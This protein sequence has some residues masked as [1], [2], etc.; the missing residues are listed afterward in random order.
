MKKA[1][2]QL[3]IAVF[4]AGFTAILGKLIG[5]NESLLVWYR[6][7]L[8]V[9]ALAI[10]L[11]Y[12]GQLKKI[13]RKE[14]L[15]IFGVGGI[16]AFHWLTFYGSVKYANVSVAVVCL[17][18][19]G[20][21]TAFLEPL[22]FNKKIKLVEV[23]L[24]ILAIAGIYIIFDFHPQYKVGIVFG[25]L[26]A[27]GSSLFPIFNKRL[28]VRYSPLVLTFYELS[29]G[30]LVLTLVVPL[31]LYYFPATY[32]LPT[33]LDGWWLLVLA[34]LCTVVC[35]DLQLNALKKISPF[36]SNLAYNLEPVYGIIFAFAIFQE[37]KSLNPQFYG[38]LVLII[39]AVALQTFR[40]TRLKPLPVLHI[41]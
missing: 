13:P 20:F 30:I 1:L 39:L 37:N 32:Y 3:H 14:M 6:L 21:F 11:Y 22:I 23:L 8:T 35:F 27:L 9:I 4:L 28:I 2:I 31:Y 24:G 19:S 12:K 33:I 17:A 40:I 41:D 7:L 38:G 18:G 10:I 16:V 36:T 26:A 25:I 5:L 15:Q 34:L 29:G